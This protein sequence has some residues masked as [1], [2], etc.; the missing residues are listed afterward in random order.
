MIN[1]KII[2]K[3]TLPLINKY[4]TKYFGQLFTISSFNMKIKSIVF[5]ALITLFLP[6]TLLSEENDTFVVDEILHFNRYVNTGNNQEVFFVFSISNKDKNIVHSSFDSVDDK[7]ITKHTRTANLYNF[8]YP[9]G[10]LSKIELVKNR[11][12]FI[13]NPSVN[14]EIYKKDELLYKFSSDSDQYYDIRYPNCVS[15]HGDG[16]FWEG[17]IRINYKKE[18]TQHI[19]DILNVNKWSA[20]TAIYSSQND[21]YIELVGDEVFLKGDLCTND[22]CEVLVNVKEGE[23]FNAIS[24]INGLKNG[25]CATKEPAGAGGDIEPIEAFIDPVDNEIEKLKTGNIVF[26]TPSSMYK[27]KTN[28]ISLKL[29]ATKNIASLLNELDGVEKES[30][31]IM[32]SNRMKAELISD[33]NAFE[34]TS[35][36]PDI[37]AISSVN[38]TTWK[39]DVTP[40]ELGDQ[41][42]HLSLTA[43]LIIEGK[44]TPL[45][46]KTFDKVIKVNVSYTDE[47]SFFIQNNWKW[48]FGSLL[49]PLAGFWWKNNY[50]KKET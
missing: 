24:K 42:L 5:I 6:S 40:L 44:E 21:D 39:W 38:T 9:N 46:I 49:F 25:T 14:V 18:M 47:I 32:Y 3:Y 48:I 8:I 33:K 43:F 41:Y 19:I 7:T 50:N 4:V 1:E 35:I 28:I 10:Y 31:V 13:E 34:I 27:N 22:K 16:G 26:N 15:S 37:Q 11:I 30:A 17:V 36:S 12:G 23:E 2:K 45:S 29:D 20:F